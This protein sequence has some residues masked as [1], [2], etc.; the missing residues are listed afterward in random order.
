MVPYH[1]PMVISVPRP[2]VVAA[3]FKRMDVVAVAQ[4]TNMASRNPRNPTLTRPRRGTNADNADTTFAN[5]A[6]QFAAFQ[7]PSMLF[8][9]IT[10]QGGDKNWADYNLPEQ[11]TAGPSRTRQYGS[12]TDPDTSEPDTDVQA[13]PTPAPRGRGRG[14][15][16]GR[17]RGRGQAGDNQDVPVAGTSVQPHT[18][19]E[20]DPPAPPSPARQTGAHD[21]SSSSSSAHSQQ[22]SPPRSPSTEGED[23]GHIFEDP[24]TPR[25]LAPAAQLSAARAQRACGTPRFGRRSRVAAVARDGP[26]GNRKRY[27][28]L[29]VWSFFTAINQQNYCVF[30]E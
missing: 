21:S 4:Y 3:G 5:G 11:P 23:L 26:A 24:S 28:A 30:C 10:I 22:D 13:T 2:Y 15:S 12:N 20:H 27:A 1:A 8:F 19:A 29:D 7:I 14:R 9:S 25:R 16:R 17:G 18:M 6:R